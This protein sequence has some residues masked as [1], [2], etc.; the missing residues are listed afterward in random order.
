ME[1][2]H[3]VLSRHVHVTM[4][5]E[6]NLTLSFCTNYSYELHP[7]HPRTSSTICAVSHPACH[8][9]SDNEYNREILA[10]RISPSHP[11]TNP[12]LPTE[13]QNSISDFTEDDELHF[14]PTSFLF[15]QGLH[16]CGLRLARKRTSIGSISGATFTI[17]LT[18]ART[19]ASGGS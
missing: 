16:H 6:I 10:L 9:F 7:L 19:R 3:I 8:G 4:T 12:S 17:A 5:T 11:A 14:R 1:C 13:L 2:H 15:S 18:G